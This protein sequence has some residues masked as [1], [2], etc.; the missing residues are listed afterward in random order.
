MNTQ[1]VMI[2]LE[3][4]ADRLAFTHFQLSNFSLIFLDAVRRGLWEGVGA[5]V[6]EMEF[7]LRRRFDF[8][9]YR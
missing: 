5:A 2:T 6:M 4:E 1:R 8:K 9:S 7:A 3:A